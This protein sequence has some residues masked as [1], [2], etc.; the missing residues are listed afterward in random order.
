[1]THDFKAAQSELNSKEQD[2]WDNLSRKKIEAI[3]GA[4]ELA[5]SQGNI[6][7][8]CGL[9]INVCNFMAVASREIAKI[10]SNDLP[11]MK[12]ETSIRKIFEKEYRE[13][14][15][16]EVITIVRVT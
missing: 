2:Y 3:Y 12:K 9:P 14:V 15:L 16:G 5:I 11:I 8:E 10:N 6:C 13:W 1:M 7:D 4:L